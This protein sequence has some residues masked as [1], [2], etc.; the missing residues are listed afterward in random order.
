MRLIQVFC[1]SLLVIG[2]SCQG[3]STPDPE[4]A[5]KLYQEAKSLDRDDD[6]DRMLE[7]YRQAV[8]H[9]PE[10]TEAHWEIISLTDDKERLRQDY[11]RRVRETPNSAVFRYLLGEVSEGET[12][13]TQYE[14]AIELDSHYPWSYVGLG[15][16]LE[17]LTSFDEAI[18]HYRKMISVLPDEAEGYWGL[19]RTYKKAGRTDEAASFLQQIYERFRNDPDVGPRALYQIADSVE[20][21]SQKARLWH[22]FLEDYP[23][24]P[25]IAQVHNHLLKHYLETDQQRAEAFAHECL[26]KEETPDDRRLHY[27]AYQALFEL[28]WKSGETEKEGKLVQALMESGYA[29][30]YAY[31]YVAYHYAKEGQTE[32]AIRFFERALDFANPDSV[33]GTVLFTSREPSREWLEEVA[34]N[35]RAGISYELGEL[36]NKTRKYQEAVAV[37]LPVVG[38][39]DRLGDRIH[40]ELAAAYEAIGKH[41]EALKHYASSLIDFL[42]DPARKP[43]ESLFT[44]VHGSIEGLNQ[45]VLDHV[46]QPKTGGSVALGAPTALSLDEAILRARGL[47]SGEAP[48]FNLQTLGGDSIRS[49]DLKGK[50]VVLDFWATWCGP[51]IDELPQFQATVDRWADRPE[52][53]FLAVSVDEDDD[54]VRSFMTKNEYDFPVAR[55]GEVD[56]DFGVSVLPTIVLIGKEGRIQYRHVGFDP[57]SDLTRKLSDEIDFLLGAGVS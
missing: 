24:G 1:C 56:D 32:L 3:P 40:F 47:S 57:D 4:T 15:E 39:W 23:A 14:E 42:H 51:C 20:D 34:G 46:T 41:H 6:A 38:V 54:V 9:D 53:V 18:T 7:L 11:E 10:Y 44:K 13:R 29:H 12:K 52:V 33:H 27:Y 45:Y 17:D 2:P 25:R 19:L 36:L 50:V 21:P 16:L 49:A 37:L 35:V 5:R 43:L 55:D 31:T 28:Y 30:P 8:E 26:A 48:E 22:R